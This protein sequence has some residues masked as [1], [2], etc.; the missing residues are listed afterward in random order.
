MQPY[1]LYQNV[2]FQSCVIIGNRTSRKTEY[3][4]E[5][6]KRH[7]ITV[8]NRIFAIAG[9]KQSRLQWKQ[10]NRFD[11][12]T[13]QLNLIRSIIT[14]QYQPAIIKTLIIDGCDFNKEF[15]F[16]DALAKFLLDFNSIKVNVIFILQGLNCCPVEL[17]RFFD[18]RIFILSRPNQSELSFYAYVCNISRER[19]KLYYRDVL[20]R[21]PLTVFVI[22]NGNCFY[23]DFIP[24]I[25]ESNQL[26]T[27]NNKSFNEVYCSIDSNTATLIVGKRGCG[28]TKFIK[29]ILARDDKKLEKT[30]IVMTQ[31]RWEWENI[32]PSKYV[33]SPS[34]ELLED[35]TTLPNCLFT[36]TKNQKIIILDLDSVPL[37]RPLEWKD[38]LQSCHQKEISVIVSVQKIMPAC[39]NFFFGKTY[40][41][42]AQR[43]W[44]ATLPKMPKFSSNHEF[45]SFDSI[46]NTMMICRWPS[47]LLLQEELVLKSDRAKFEEDLISIETRSQKILRTVAFYALFVALKIKEKVE[48]V[49]NMEDDQLLLATDAYDESKLTRAKTVVLLPQQDELLQPKSS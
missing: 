26:K 33:L 49:N 23:D 19:I 7:F 8:D 48:L 38:F 17:D 6:L 40:F 18:E 43:K 39:T 37:F 15:M 11:A 3:A 32:I 41:L 24:L 27:T 14:N 2:G 47:N 4:K 44:N 29:Q 13:E 34:K 31:R 10:C 46:D 22:Q 28:K 1:Y 12:T 45:I 25:V 42:S 35:I 16:S 20:K 21:H 30:Y 9:N 5:I 36:T